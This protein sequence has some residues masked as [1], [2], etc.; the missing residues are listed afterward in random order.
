MKGDLIRYYLNTSGYSRNDFLQVIKFKYL[1]D[2]FKRTA[3]RA[4][5]SEAILTD[6]EVIWKLSAEVIHRDASPM[7]KLAV[8]R[9]YSVKRAGRQQRK[10]IY[11]DLILA[12]WD[13]YGFTLSE[14][15]LSLV[16]E[17]NGYRVFL[18]KANLFLDA[19]GIRLRNTVPLANQAYRANVRKITHGGL[20]IVGEMGMVYHTRVPVSN[21][22]D[23]DVF[24]RDVK[25]AFDLIRQ[26]DTSLYQLMIQRLQWIIFFPNEK[27]ISFTDSRLP[28]S[29]FVSPNAYDGDTFLLA[30]ALIHEFS[31]LELAVIIG[32]EPIF[33]DGG[34]LFR[35]PWR[36][37]SRPIGG[38]V[39]GVYVFT[40]VLRFFHLALPDLSSSAS[41]M[42]K[43]VQNQ[44]YVA[45]NQ[46]PPHFFT[47][48]GVD[49]M[50]DLKSVLEEISSATI[51][52][53]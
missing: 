40:Q 36:D 46:L 9:V 14:S 27:R 5:Y 22:K 26:Y 43:L 21:E 11:A 34:Q 24:E 18:Q 33:K 30:A 39:H 15:F 53:D 38:I 1:P 7:F 16:N 13:C 45:H 49:M 12:A 50:A 31:H 20:R 6:L 23:L 41:E 17:L 10:V 47:G 25:K 37:D 3:W 51:V 2:Y 4:Y 28:E 19:N 8:N 48:L 52:T 35:S 44:L 32:I 29:I 42:Y